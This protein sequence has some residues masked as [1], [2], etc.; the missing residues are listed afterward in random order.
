MGISGETSQ[1]TEAASSGASPDEPG[2]TDQRQQSKFGKWMS[3]LK[4]QA[5]WLLPNLIPMPY[6]RRDAVYQN[7]RDKEENEKGSIPS[8]IELRCP[9]IWGV[10]L[11]G[12]S[13]IESLYDGIGKLGWNRV[14]ARNAEVNAVDRIRQQR[15]DGPGG[16]LNIG[17]VLPKGE[18]QLFSLT[19]N[20]SPMPEGVESLLVRVFQITTSLTA[21]LVGFR[22][23]DPLADGYEREA[24]RDRVTFYR[25]ARR[26]RAIEWVQPWHQKQ[27]AV[28]VARRKLRSMAG[29]WF[30]RNL[31]GYFCGLVRPSEFPTM[32]LLIAQGSIFEDSEKLPSSGWMDWRRLLVNTPPH[33]IWTYED[34]Q[35]LQLAFEREYDTPEG[36]HIVVALDAKNFPEEK[37]SRFGRSKPAAY[38]WHCDE[39]LDGILV[40]SAAVEYLKEQ[41]RDLN[42]T[43]DRM[44]KVRSGRKNLSR[45]LVEIGDFFDRTLGSSVVA[46]E[47]ATHSED[48]GWYRHDCANFTAPGWDRESKHTLHEVICRR[49][50]FH[51]SQ[52]SDEEPALRGHFEQLSTIMSVRESIRAQRRMEWL[53]LLALLIALASLAIALP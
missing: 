22:L 29:E 53:T 26:Q 2:S 14:G 35:G 18:Q 34:S 1:K 19:N 45:T 6:S 51:S 41:I 15:I 42:L 16:W 33:E 47:L 3:K 52:L 39:I 21:V 36:L 44:K 10:E 8:E 24:N 7:T 17:Q 11:Y 46:R 12:P 13:E 4:W 20:F 9:M 49:V 43:R 28:R 5:Y 38:S 31:P 27:E 48:V 30:S 32:E 50:R 40:H 25:P 23:R 37:F